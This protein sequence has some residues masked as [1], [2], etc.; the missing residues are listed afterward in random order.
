[1]ILTIRP[2]KNLYWRQI[3]ENPEG[4]ISDIEMEGGSQTLIF[5]KG[6]EYSLVIIKSLSGNSEVKLAALGEDGIH[7]TIFTPSE[8]A[9]NR[10]EIIS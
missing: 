4:E 1:M 3:F 2:T 7:Y 9:K 8:F 5:K 6:R 10:F